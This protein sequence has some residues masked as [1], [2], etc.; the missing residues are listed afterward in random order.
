MNTSIYKIKNKTN[1]KFY[2]GSTNDFQRRWAEH[3]NDLR[4][5]KHTNR[6]LQ[7]A[8]NKYGEEAFE[9]EVIA[10]CKEE[11]LIENEQLWLNTYAGEKF[12][13]NINENAD[14]PPKGPLSEEHKEK[15]RQSRLGKKRAPFSEEWK[16][17]ISNSVRGFKKTP[18]AIEKTASAQRKPVKVIF[19]NGETKTFISRNETAKELGIARKNIHAALKRGGWSNHP[20]VRQDLRGATIE[21]L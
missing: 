15:I 10:R 7:A 4:K 3:S 8:W 18:E 20:N 14:C 17:N 11:H 1:Q 2:I 6:H 5:N 16:R 9:F 12:C 21:Y 19:A 13:Y